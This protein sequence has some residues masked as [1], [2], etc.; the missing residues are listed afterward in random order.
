MAWSDSLPEAQQYRGDD[1]TVLIHGELFNAQELR[2]KLALDSESS[3]AQIL[4]SAWRR[5]SIDTLPRLDGVFVLAVRSADK[6]FL[7]RDPSGLRNLYFCP[8]RPGKL[9]FATD[10]GSLLRLPGVDRRLSRRSLHEY[11][12][13]LDIAAPHTW[14]EHIQSVEPGVCVTGSDGI[15]EGSIRPIADRAALAPAEFADA[16]EMLDTHLLHSVQT[17]LSDSTHPAAF[18][19]GGIDSS[20]ICALATRQRRDVTAVTVGF[21]GGSFDEAPVAGHI[22]KHLGMAHRVLRFGRR[23]YLAALEKL[24]VGM[25]Q[26]MADPATPATLLAFDYCSKSFDAVLDGTGA[27]EAVGTMPARHVRLAVGYASALPAPARRVMLRVLG[28]VPRLSDYRS[29][30]DFDH[31]A[32]T[33]IRWHGFTRS[34]IELLCGEPVSFADTQFYRTFARFRRSEHF[35]RYSALLN[36]MPCD[37]LNQATLVSGL[38]VRYPFCDR[39][40]DAFIRQLPEDWRYRK[41]EPKRIL[42]ALLSRYVPQPIWDVPKHGFDFPLLEFLSGDDYALVR[43]YLLQGRWL[44]M[45]LLRPDGVRAYALRFIAGD[46]RMKFRVWALVVLAAWLE[47]RGDLQ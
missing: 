31:P 14:F 39:K 46:E 18:L 10:L 23:D 7:Y 35:E 2:G 12:R 20:L 36:A 25:D 47:Q 43:R 21:E 3:I 8:G 19:S 9:A 11:L 41:G 17:R 5:W 24:S 45:G 28:A 26:P 37:R 40:A 42:R 38:R 30:L 32:D 4:A 6:L 13:F 34:E 44:D 1:M 15:V 16:V 22:A 33:M 27:D 29:I